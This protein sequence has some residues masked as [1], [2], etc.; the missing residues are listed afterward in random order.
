MDYNAFYNTHILYQR[1]RLSSGKLCGCYYCLKIFSPRE[2]V[3][4]CDEREEGFGE[5]AICPYCEI[6]S[7]IGEGEEYTINTEFLKKIRLYAFKITNHL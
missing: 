3:E 2:I 1:K 7:V 4:W 6:D 5:T